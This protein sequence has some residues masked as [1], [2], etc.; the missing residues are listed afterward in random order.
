MGL[1]CRGRSAV[2][3]KC[4]T[5]CSHCEMVPASEGSCCTSLKAALCAVPLQVAAA[6]TGIIQKAKKGSSKQDLKVRRSASWRG[7][8]ACPPPVPSCRCFPPRQQPL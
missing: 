5:Q 7:T 4:C 1:A 3:C 6:I 2:A 8:G